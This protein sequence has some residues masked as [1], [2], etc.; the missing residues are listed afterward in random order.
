MDKGYIYINREFL[1]LHLTSKQSQLL[2]FCLL[3][4]DKNGF[5][6]MSL[7]EIALRIGRYVSDIEIDLA[8]IDGFV[9]MSDE[10]DEFGR[11]EFKVRNYQTFCKL[12]E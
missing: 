12:E 4:M 5:F 3:Q 2:L 7:E 10:K 6:L 11:R 9:W 1:E 8:A